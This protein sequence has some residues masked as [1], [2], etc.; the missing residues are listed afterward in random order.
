MCSGKVDGMELV[1]L[2][3]ALWLVGALAVVVGADSR[4]GRSNW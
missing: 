4:D 3:V 1:I 2:V